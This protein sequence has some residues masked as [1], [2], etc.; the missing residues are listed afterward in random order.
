META[1][2]GR[3]SR[4]RPPR[5]A[6]DSTRATF[7]QNV[8]QSSSNG[9]LASS[10]IESSVWSSPPAPLMDLNTPVPRSRYIQVPHVR[11][12]C[13]WDCGLACVLM[14]LK[15][16]GFEGCD[17][18]YLSQLCQ[19][20]SIWTVD[21]AHLLRHFN[22]EVAFLTVTIGA[23]PNFA[24]E[25]FYKE[26]MEEDG[27]RVNMLFEKA[28]QVGIRVQWRSI[29]GEELSLLILSGGFLAI[30]LVDKRKLSHPWL[31]ELCLADCCGLNTGYTGHYV[32]ICGYDMDADEFEI[33]DP[34]SSST[35][36]RISLDALDEARKSFGTDEDILLV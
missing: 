2:A 21:L 1:V 25:T 11:Q 14:V 26:N 28:P 27:E 29:T 16:L 18:K 5:P 30:A 31:D 3:V 23:N 4:V 36:G 10:L 9:W 19:T 34:A 13:N 8:I 33:R 7:S 15:V 22:V 35:S 24:I 12:L 17:L 20:T 32:V 6:S